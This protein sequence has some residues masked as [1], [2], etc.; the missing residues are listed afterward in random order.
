M[1]Q[2]YS[3][4]I[5]D[6]SC[7][8]L[9]EKINEIN[10]LKAVF[11]NISTTE[12]IALEFGKP[13]PSWISIKSPSDKKYQ[14]LLQVEVD[15]GEAS[16]IALAIESHNSLIILDDYRARRLAERLE[17]KYTG[18]LG[19]FLK[20][21]EL[22]IIPNIRSVLE[23]IQKTNFRFSEKVFKEILSIANE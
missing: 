2:G 9:L 8:I 4:V 14:D 1:L 16:A 20:A 21:K 3:I 22:N 18:T 6:T 23:K 7:F 12:E 5:A 15:L 13:L 11:T 17:L 19:I 10:L